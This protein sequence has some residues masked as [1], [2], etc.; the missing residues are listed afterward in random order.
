MRV[1][2]RSSVPRV[3]IATLLNTVASCA[4]GAYAISQPAFGPYFSL[5]A[6]PVHT[7]LGLILYG[8]SLFVFSFVGVLGLRWV[9]IR[10]SATQAM[11]ASIGAVLGLGSIAG[12]LASPFFETKTQALGTSLL[13]A[14][15]CALIS[16][17]ILRPIS[18]QDLPSI[19]C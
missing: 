18:R 11:I 2:D 14:L 4:I 1:L 16:W 12:L 15:I 13:A 6:V 7:A 3:L 8:P 5:I 17:S 19:S 9:L 10:R